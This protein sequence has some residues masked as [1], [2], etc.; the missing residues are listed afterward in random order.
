MKFSKICLITF[1][2]IVFAGKV[3]A[4]VIDQEEERRRVI[5]VH[6]Q[7]C[8]YST[9]LRVAGMIGNPPFGWVERH[10]ERPTKDLESYGLG[11]MVLDK[12]AEKLHISYVSTGFLSYSQAIKA[13]KRGDIDLFLGTYY[14]PQDLGTGTSIV[15]PGYFKNVFVV[16]FKKGKEIPVSSLTDLEG[17][18]GIVRREE[19]VYPLVYQRLPDGVSLTQVSTAKRAFEMLMN[20]EADYLI[21]SPYAEE[22]ELRRYKLNEKIIPS[23]QVLLSSNLFFVFTKNSNCRKLK[24]KL[25]E[26]LQGDE[27]STA[28]MDIMVRSLINDWGERFREEP[29]LLEEEKEEET[30]NS[31]DS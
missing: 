25:A 9:P 7:G 8:G 30:E 4:A 11:R 21:G 16:Y 19:H 27:F 17:M 15:F 10:D 5:N 2:G 1:L 3:F 26:A 20:D 24:E 22:A 12:L 28:E 29:G 23:S 6:E 31:T 18:K 14:R 13:L